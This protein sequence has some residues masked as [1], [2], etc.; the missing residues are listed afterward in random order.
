VPGFV[1]ILAVINLIILGEH[2]V[3]EADWIN[4]FET[5]K[6]IKTSPTCIPDE[7]LFKQERQAWAEWWGTQIL[8]NLN[9]Y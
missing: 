2:D 9:L 1:P 5:T 7:I 6:R 3:Y 4:C 8:E